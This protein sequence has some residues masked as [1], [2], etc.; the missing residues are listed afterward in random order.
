[1]GVLTLIVACLFLIGLWLVRLPGRVGSLLDLLLERREAV[2]RGL[3][4]DLPSH[5]W[6]YAMENGIVSPHGEQAVIDAAGRVQCALIYHTVE[7]EVNGWPGTRRELRPA[8]CYRSNSGW[9]APPPKDRPWLI[10][11]KHWWSAKDRLWRSYPTE[12]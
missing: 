6:P 12:E 7:I 1:M 2:R 4:P 5:E 8:N 9:H 11:G 10:C 3:P